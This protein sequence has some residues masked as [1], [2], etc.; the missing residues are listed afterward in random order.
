MGYSSLSIPANASIQDMLM[1]VKNSV[2]GSLTFRVGNGSGSPTSGVRVN[3]RLAL[4]D[5]TVFLM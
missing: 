2:D 4:A 1:A 5:I 3:G